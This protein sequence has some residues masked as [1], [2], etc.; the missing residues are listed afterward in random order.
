[1]V[2]AAALALVLL[3]LSVAQAQ[4]VYVIE[5]PGFAALTDAQ[6]DII[7]HDASAD[8]IFEVVPD[9]LY[10]VG[11]AGDYG[12]FDAEGQ[13]VGDGRYEML[14][15]H[16]D[17][18]LFRRNGRFGAMDLNSNVLIEP[19]WAQLTCAGEGKYL[20]LQG[21]LYDDQPDELISLSADRAG[22]PTGSFTANG[23]HAFS[24]DRMAF[25]QSDGQYGYVDGDGRQV[26]PPQW[27]Y[28]GAFSGGLAIVS[29]DGGMG[30]ID[31]GGGIVLDPA[32]AWVQRGE[33]F[34][35]A[36][37]SNGQLDVYAENGA[38]LT[39]S[40]DSVEEVEVCGSY[41]VARRGDR[42]LVYDGQGRR[43]CEADRAALFRP[44]LNGQLIIFDGAWGEACERVMNPDGSAATGFYQRLLPLCGGR[45]A[46][47]TF[48]PG[49]SWGGDSARC[50][51]LSDDGR[52]LLP[53]Q[54]LDILPAGA[55][56]LVLVTGDAV[57]FA[58]LDG[59]ILREW[60]INETA[61]SSSEEGA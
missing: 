26:V 61:A 50:G 24:E 38:A 51:L 60:P 32:Y 22:E 16:K 4:D 17:A 21:D 2:R 55:D 56:R 33:G 8:A 14:E 27:R 47:M 41:V 1:M 30:L 42:A 46:F 18:V 9:R 49:D 52:E 6:G 58:D 23:L 59:N 20:A 31:A 25:M 34:F 35:A 7:L 43:V 40:L 37:R 13:G 29:G 10:A 5:A 57:R 39:L 54:Y 19:E 44:G 48:V 36:L 12:L 53:A 3:M 28:A 45:Y 15:A 11:R